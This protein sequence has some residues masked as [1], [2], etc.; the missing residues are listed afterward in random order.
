ME[1]SK[2]SSLAT[3]ISQSRTAEAV[4]M[5]VLK[6]S[7]DL[8]LQAGAQLIQAATPVASRSPPHLGS[9]IDVFA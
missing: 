9:Q 1:A 7:M 5:A 3:S 4:Q 2:M 6:K 8:N